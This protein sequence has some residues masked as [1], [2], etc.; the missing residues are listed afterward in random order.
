[1]NENNQPDN[2]QF[3]SFFPPEKPENL[4]VEIP[5]EPRPLP[6]DR[7]PRGYDP[8]GEI[9]LRGRSY[10]GLASGQVPWWVLI[11]GWVIFGGIAALLLHVAITS[12][13]LTSWIWVA[14]AALLLLVLGR[15][16]VAKLSSQRRR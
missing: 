12:A 16:T 9:Q 10:R 7:I 6:A 4:S 11:T 3:E 5:A 15:G 14:I 8:M 13:T 1:M 2:D